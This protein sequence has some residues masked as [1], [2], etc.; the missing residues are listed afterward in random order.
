MT[1]LQRLRR[2]L[3]GRTFKRKIFRLDVSHVDGTR[4]GANNDNGDK[5]TNRD[6]QG[7]R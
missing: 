4:K 1:H 5:D 3:R 2:R 6:G 7:P